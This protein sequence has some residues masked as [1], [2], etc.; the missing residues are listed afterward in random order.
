MAEVTASIHID[1]KLIEAWVM[2]HR[3]QIPFAQSKAINE[4][5]QDLKKRALP[6]GAKAAFDSPTNFTSSS[7]AWRI[8]Y[9]T[10]KN[11][12]ALVYP[13]AKREPYLRAHITGGERGV[14]KSEAF[15][16]GVGVGSAPADQFFPTSHAKRNNQGNV[17]KAT[18][19]RI[20]L[21]ARDKTPGRGKHFIGKPANSTQPYGIYKRMARKIRPIYLPATKPMQYERIYDIGGIADEVI[22]QDYERLFSKHFAN[23]LRTAK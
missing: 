19:E 2:G 11:V 18:I 16:R 12:E 14:K 3:R 5:A 15:F 21:Q 13:Q 4:I 7:A 17:R 9:S 1:R 20:I 23:A 22:S 10:K 8:Q 6:E